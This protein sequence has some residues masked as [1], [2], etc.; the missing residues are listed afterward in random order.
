MKFRISSILVWVP[1]F[2]AVLLS[3]V[4]LLLMKQAD[5][6]RK[7]EAATTCSYFVNVEQYAG[8]EI[9][10][11]VSVVTSESLPQV[12]FEYRKQIQ[13]EQVTDCSTGACYLD[14]CK[15]VLYQDCVDFYEIVTL[16]DTV[17]YY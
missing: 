15:I 17:L 9:Q 12:E 16:R 2:N 14:S 1:L 7:I 8:G 6:V 10:N 4:V 11:Y 3:A 13:A 5:N